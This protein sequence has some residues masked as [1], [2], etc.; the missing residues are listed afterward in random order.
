[1]RVNKSSIAEL[2][3]FERRHPASI[4][5]ESARARLKELRKVA[6]VTPPPPIVSGTPLTRERER[7]LKPGDTFKECNVCP[8]MVVV[9]AGNFMM[10][11]PTSE[12]GREPRE[13]PRHRV[14]IARPFAVGKFEVTFAEWDACVAAAG[15]NY[16]PE[17][18]GGRNKLPVVMVSWHDITTEYLPWL[19]RTTGKY[20]RLL[21]E[22]E[23]EYAARAGT[24]TPI[25]TGH[26]VA[27]AQVNLDELRMV[28]VD[29]FSPNPWGLYQ[30]NGNAH[31]WVEDCWHNNYQGSPGNGSAW[32]TGNCT[33][34]VYRTG[35][36]S[37]ARN[38]ERPDPR[39][40]GRNSGTGFR[41]ARTLDP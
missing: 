6:V 41:V 29:S 28:A 9:P 11:S 2:E 12:K 7:A 19:A 26:T 38:Y 15:C 31:E 10:G 16:R 13:G 27:P 14:T 1:V 32:N 40:P 23:W 3:T 4:E 18:F 8:E 21:T 17:D 30:M 5:A 39:W 22:A 37:A 35:R 36:R 33:N 34:R 20:Y 24:T 25:W